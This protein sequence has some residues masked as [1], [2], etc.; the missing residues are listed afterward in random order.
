MCQVVLLWH[1]YLEVHR[2]LKGSWHQSI[3]ALLLYW[4]VF[5]KCSSCKCIPWRF[6]PPPELGAQG[7]TNAHTNTHTTPWIIPAKPATENVRCIHTNYSPKDL[8]PARSHPSWLTCVVLLWNFF[9]GQ[10][11]HVFAAQYLVQRFTQSGNWFE[12]CEVVMCWF[13]WL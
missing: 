9:E 10:T 5:K 1:A 6:E 8:H 12:Y 2:S 13:A 11:E 3:T 7:S 4:E